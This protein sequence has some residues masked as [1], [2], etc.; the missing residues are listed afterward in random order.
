MAR[1]E[2]SRLLDP[3]ADSPRLRLPK[4]ADT[5]FDLLLDR[6]SHLWCRVP[7][8]MIHSHVIMEDLA[9]EKAKLGSGVKVC[10]VSDSN[11]GGIKSASSSQSQICQ[12]QI[13]PQVMQPFNNTVNPFPHGQTM[14]TSIESYLK[15][16][17]TLLNSDQHGSQ[18]IQQK[19]ETCNVEEK[20]SVLEEVLANAC[21]LMTDVFGNYVMQK[22]FKHGSPEQRKQLAEQLVGHVLELTLQLYG[23]CVIQ[24]IMMKVRFANY[25]VL[26][27]LETCSD[28]QENLLNRIRLHLQALKYTY[29][30]HIVGRVEQWSRGVI[31]SSCLPYVLLFDF[32][33]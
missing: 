5:L 19:L 33:E 10:G 21:T 23:C 8:L 2:V 29:G 7:I 6:C 11:I 22:F 1:R 15:L 20:A 9:T 17:V 25:V 30:K 24:K 32:L 3:M 27:I 28:K 26:K 31:D 4:L 13:V 14:I 18:C 12:S 16:L